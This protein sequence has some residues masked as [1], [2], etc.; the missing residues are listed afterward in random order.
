MSDLF[1]WLLGNHTIIL[2][3]EIEVSLKE[4]LLG[5]LMRCILLKPFTFFNGSAFG[6]KKFE[7]DPGARPGKMG[8]PM[9][10]RYD[11]LTFFRIKISLLLKP[12]F[13]AAKNHWRSNYEIKRSIGFSQRSKHC[14]KT[15]RKQFFSTSRFSLL[16]PM[17]QIQRGVPFLLNIGINL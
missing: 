14:R 2:N 5:V 1:K 8:R 12:N 15:N 11:Q 17:R 9:I 10:C 16:I 4:K 6:P 13:S 7:P 3:L